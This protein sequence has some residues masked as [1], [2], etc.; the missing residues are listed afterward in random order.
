MVFGVSKDKTYD[1]MLAILPKDALYYWCAADLPRSLSALD[2]KQAGER[3]ALSG[4]G[5][6]S[7]ETSFAALQ[8]VNHRLMTCFCGREFLCSG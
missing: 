7:V 5:F 8:S 6:P 4:T 1:D 2:L 3:F